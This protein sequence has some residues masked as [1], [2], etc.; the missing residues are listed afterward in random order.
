MYINVNTHIMQLTTPYVTSSPN[1]LRS[2]LPFPP[3]GKTKSYLLLVHSDEE[4]KDNHTAAEEHLTGGAFTENG[5]GEKHCE[6][7]REGAR[8]L[9]ECHAHKLQAVVVG[10]EHE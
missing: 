10:G 2:L 8:D 4:A 1:A 7:E 5:N 9:E 6:Y 3:Y